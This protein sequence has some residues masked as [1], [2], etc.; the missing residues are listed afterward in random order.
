MLCATPRENERKTTSI[1]RPS[2]LGFSAD[3]LLPCDKSLLVPAPVLKSSRPFFNQSEKTACADLF[4]RRHDND[5]ERIYDI[6]VAPTASEILS[7][8]P[9]YVPQNAPSTWDRMDHLKVR[10]ESALEGGDLWHDSPGIGII[11]PR[12][13]LESMLG[14][15]AGVSGELRQGFRS[16]SV[17]PA[18][19]LPLLR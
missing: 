8:R 19:Q 9:P 18:L 16:V 10:L 6:S 11:A 1:F 2:V 14:E 13:F 12:R 3:N 5:A 7:E 17:V 4:R 15:M